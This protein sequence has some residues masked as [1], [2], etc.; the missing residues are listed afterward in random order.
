M[1]ITKAHIKANKKSIISTFINNSN[2]VIEKTT[3]SNYLA[4]AMVF[5]QFCQMML[6]TFNF[7]NLN[8]APALEKVVFYFF[9]I[10]PHKMLTT[11]TLPIFIGVLM[12]NVL[13]FFISVYGYY[14][15]QQVSK[16]S[17]V[18]QIY[19]IFLNFFELVVCPL[20]IGM[21]VSFFTLPKQLSVPLQ[22]LGF[23]SFSIFGIANLALILITNLFFSNFFIASKDPLCRSPSPM[24]I[25]NK[26]LMVIVLSAEI[27]VPKSTSPWLIDLM[28]L[29]L[30][31]FI[32]FDYISRIPY[33]Q[34]F[35]SSTYLYSA[36]LYF[37]INFLI[38]ISV[39]LNVELVR[40][41]VLILVIV[42]AFF[43][44]L[45]MYSYRGFIRN[46]LLAIDF[47]HLQND[48]LIEKKIRLFLNL[49]KNSK[50]DKADELRLA[51]LI[52]YHI[53]SCKN[54][55]CVCTKPQL[56]YNALKDVS[57]SPDLP[58]F[59]DFVFVK[60]IF[61]SMIQEM[62]PKIRSSESLSIIYIL[63]LLEITQNFALCGTECAVY[64]RHFKNAS[65]FV[66]RVCI[67]RI[68]RSL[69]M[70]LKEFN[71]KTEISRNKFEK[72]VD[73][74]SRMQK[75][76]FDKQRHNSRFDQQIPS[77]LAYFG[78]RLRRGKSVE[79]SLSS[80]SRAKEA[81]KAPF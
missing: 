47:K 81:R 78:G 52:K 43:L 15:S 1:G 73:Y 6:V 74:D 45:I 18:I 41:N 79:K 11:Y 40:Q 56:V 33:S 13:M 14:I 55:S 31:F 53:D 42:G 16:K 32:C 9:I 24:F 35:I 49:V 26:L 61:L 72:L 51:S 50:K 36:T 68:K 69:A 30:S 71:L 7:A 28:A 22:L 27:I 23:V 77:I 10:V 8:L 17:K 58:V 60:S 20:L 66:S 54:S 48:N 44:L 37:W 4:A 39:N 19:F 64:D 59:K 21:I 3:F 63:Y 65:G 34:P 25:V 12:A 67:E 80:N 75:L 5:L 70:K 38:I 2:K 46:T 57:A 62:K 76:K 29:L